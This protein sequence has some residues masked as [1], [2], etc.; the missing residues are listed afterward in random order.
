[1]GRQT[2]ASSK[3]QAPKD[4]QQNSN[5]P[6]MTDFNRTKRL[7]KSLSAEGFLFG[8]WRLGALALVWDLLLVVWCFWISCFEFVSDFV[9]R[10]SNFLSGGMFINS[11]PLH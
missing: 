3:S 9:L 2:K 7:P 10:I 8:P 6:Q 4:K 11:E 5:N 1:V